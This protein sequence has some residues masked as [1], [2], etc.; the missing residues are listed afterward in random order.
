M[1]SCFRDKKKLLLMILLNLMS[2]TI[3]AQTLVSTKKS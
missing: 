1:Q 3:Y 2:V